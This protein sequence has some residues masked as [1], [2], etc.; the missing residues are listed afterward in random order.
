[1][2]GAQANEPAAAMNTTG[3]PIV[4]SG[5]RPRPARATARPRVRAA[6]R[7]SP[8]R[9]TYTDR[10]GRGVQDPAIR[11]YGS[12]WVGQ[13]CERAGKWWRGK[14]I[15]RFPCGTLVVVRSRLLRTIT[16]TL[17]QQDSDPALTDGSAG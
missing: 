2:R 14:T 8:T 4:L 1:M 13:Q 9:Y 10:D 6:R 15:V 17:V 7:D 3:V 5:Q 16:L 11:A 12:A